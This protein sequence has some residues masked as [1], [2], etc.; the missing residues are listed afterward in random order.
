MLRARIVFQLVL[1]FLPA[2]LAAS[3]DFLVPPGPQDNPLGIVTGPDGNLWYTNSNSHRIGRVTPTGV[4][5]T[6]PV[7]GGVFPDQIAKGADGNLW[8]TDALADFVGRITTTGA[9]TVF[10]LTAGADPVGITLGPDNNIWFTEHG[11]SRVA[12]ITSTGTITEFPTGAGTDPYKLTTGS[13]GNLWFTNFES[14]FIGRLTPQGG[15]TLF[16]IPSGGNGAAITLGPD[17]NIWFTE[18]DVD[19]VAGVTPAGT[20]SEVALP[21]FGTGAAITSGPD[22]ELW[23][24]ELGY[25]GALVA[26][27]E[28]ANPVT[29]NILEFF[30]PDFSEFGGITSGPHG[31]LW[32]TGTFS[33]S[34]GPLATDGTQPA[35]AYLLNHGS[36]VNYI[37]R[38]PDG[39]M[40][41]TALNSN[42]VG[43]ITP[44]GSVTQY[45]IPTADSSPQKIVAAPD[46]NLWFTEDAGQIGMVTPAGAIDE[47]LIQG[48]GCPHG[49]TVGSDNN[50]WV[51]DQCGLVERFT[52]TNPPV[53]TDFSV[54][55]DP[56]DIVSGPDGNL[57]FTEFSGQLIGRMST[58]GVL[59]EFATPDNTFPAGIAAGA[60]GNL[61]FQNQDIGGSVGRIT[62]AGVIDIF[63]AGLSGCA[64]DIISAGDGGLWIPDPCLLPVNRAL[65]RVSS[66]GVVTAQ[67]TS[68]YTNSGA[69]GIAVGPDGRLWF[70]EFNASRIG[71]MSAI[72]G[73]GMP[74]VAQEGAQFS[75]KVASFVDGTPT[76]KVSDFTASI[77]WGDGSA[78]SAGAVSGS[79][80]GPFDVSGSHIYLDESAAPLSLT[81]TLHDTV[82]NE[83]YPA[84]STATVSDAPLVA[85]TFALPA[86]NCVEGA[87]CSLRLASFKD[88][89]PNGAAGDFSAVINWGDGQSSNGIVSLG[90]CGSEFCVSGSHPYAEEGSYAPSVQISDIGGSQLSLNSASS[91]VISVAVADAPLTA[92]G[93]FLA[94]PHGMPLTN[95]VVA[96]FTDANPN[97]QLGETRDHQVRK[98]HA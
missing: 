84:S 17:G 54:T 76:A 16:P 38:G 50:L 91:N 89:N 18:N 45:P 28:P 7:P 64:A 82:D 83:D 41:F 43:K 65:A 63:S 1:L 33:D 61:W 85:G 88:A 56:F 57:W 31:N 6:F 96:S 26:A 47:F 9:I 35:S 90:N 5:T 36:G 69:T 92:Q 52:P 73:S 79:Q 11:L 68:S 75:G 97:G 24:R 71:R 42:Q 32:L 13:D 20:I 27:I 22:G 81:V 10:P 93:R 19:E 2:S 80:G 55:Y 23:V 14:A 98:R 44:S 58:A 8:F 78:P 53:E 59:T 48:F 66:L 74:I 70:T 15:V 49:I 39:N 87:A 95:L 60:D 72:S 12:R 40:W 67:Q 37:A 46:G 25:G 51:A 30:L 34:I 62:P 21:S 77:N 94:A 4:I 86:G 3:T 29:G